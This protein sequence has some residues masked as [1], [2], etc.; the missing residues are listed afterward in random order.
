MS[1]SSSDTSDGTPEF[2]RADFPELVACKVMPKIEVDA[3]GEEVEVGDA[4]GNKAT[5]NVPPEAVIRMN[6]PQIVPAVREH[7]VLPKGT[8]KQ[9]ENDIAMGLL[10]CRI[11][12]R[13]DETK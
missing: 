1:E 12:E 10:F 4:E 6:M 2:D 8:V 5:F 3:K 11:A 9:L 7:G 13:F